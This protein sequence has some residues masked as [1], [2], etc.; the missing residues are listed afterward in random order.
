MAPR[1]RASSRDITVKYFD[2]VDSNTYASRRRP[3]SWRKQFI[4]RRAPQ[5]SKSTSCT[6]N[7]TVNY[8]TPISARTSKAGGDDRRAPAI[9]LWLMAREGSTL[10]TWLKPTHFCGSAHS[11]HRAGHV[12]IQPESFDEVQYGLKYLPIWS[13]CWSRFGETA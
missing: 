2:L 6:V 4:D 5:P 12:S 3:K 1:E 7:C 8:L 10:C 11:S 13:L 9:L